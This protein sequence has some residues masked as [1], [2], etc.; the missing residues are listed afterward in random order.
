MF[1]ISL[2][3]MAVIGA[4]ALVVIGPERLPKVARTLGLLVGR[5]Q[6]FANSVKA[7][8]DR[9]IA[10]SELAKLEAEMRAQGA[11]LR[12]TIHQPLADAKAALL[13]APADTPAPAVIHTPAEPAVTPLPEP[14]QFALT[15]ADQALRPVVEPAAA[16]VV[17][18]PA[19]A[20][21]ISPAAHDERQ[22]DLFEPSVPTA[23][24]TPAR[25]R[26]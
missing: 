21:Q 18:A 20:P 9:E 15:A 16:T 23:A 2:G 1:D 26:R 25:D 8:L 13:A 17:S 3:E 10:Q 14:E 5:A 11:E 12:N 6:R 22:L 7:D 24:P 4:V 19:P